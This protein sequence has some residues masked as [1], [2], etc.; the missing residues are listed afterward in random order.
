MTSF[1]TITL[2]MMAIASGLTPMLAQAP[3]APCTYSRCALGIIP[4]LSA[5]DVVRGG[6]RGA[7]RILVIFVSS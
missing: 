4:R 6:D 2:A 3:D 5:L 1:T 7:R